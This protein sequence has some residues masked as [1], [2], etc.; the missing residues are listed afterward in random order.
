MTESRMP[1]R[2]SCFVMARMW[3]RSMRELASYCGTTE[4]PVNRSTISTSCRRH[5]LGTLTIGKN[6]LWL[7]SGNVVAPVSFDLKTGESKIIPASREPEWNA[8][9]VQIPEPAGK[10]LMVFAD[11]FL[12]HGGRLLYSGEGPVVSSAQISF[13]AL[14]EAGQAV[15]SAFTPVRFCA[16]PPAWDADV[17]VMPTSR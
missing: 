1:R 5:R 7:A 2:G 15:S 8:V 13:R 4:Q 17:F 3:W 10:D 6:R 11:R 14:G 12:M 9:M 16:I